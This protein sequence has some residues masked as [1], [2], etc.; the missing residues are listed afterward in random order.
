MEK[1]NDDSIHK[2]ASFFALT[3]V[4]SALIYYLTSSYPLVQLTLT[5]RGTSL[6][7]FQR[8]LTS[9]RQTIRWQDEGT[10]TLIDTATATAIDTTNE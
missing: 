6:A 3:A 4:G 1:R 8:R 7:I 10:I 2:L 9:T 5:L